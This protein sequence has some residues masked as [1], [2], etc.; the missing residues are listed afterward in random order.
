MK[1]K[2]RKM[3]DEFYNYKYWRD[4]QRNQLSI[5]CNIFFTFNVVI[6]G[7]VVDYLANDDNHCG[8]NLV[9]KNLFLVAMVFLILSIVSYVIFNILILIDY[10]NTAQIILREK[11]NHYVSAKT[12]YM[13]QINWI[14]FICQITLSVLGL[15][16]ILFSFYQIIFR[17]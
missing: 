17:D 2:K 11:S 14:L 4:I 16:I 3:L 6:L 5:S 13:G 1:K 10:R 15:L 9:I 12:K 7:F 8:M